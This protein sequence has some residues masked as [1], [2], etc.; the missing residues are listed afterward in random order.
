MRTAPAFLLVL[1][2]MPVLAQ[3]AITLPPAV[4]A[5]PAATA[6]SPDVQQ[7]LE[8]EVVALKGSSE[9][10]S[11]IVFDDELKPYRKILETLDPN[12]TFTIIAQE[13]KPVTLN[14]EERFTVNG[15]Y[16]AY[17]KPLGTRETPEGGQRHELDMR[18]EMLSGTDYVNALRARGEAADR[19]AMVLRGMNLDVGELIVLIRVVPSGQDS[20]G[21]DGDPSEQDESGEQ[22]QEQQE[23]QQQRDQMAE[24]NEDRQDQQQDKQ[25]D[26]E[27]EDEEAPELKAAQEGEHEA[28]ESGEEEMAQQAEGEQEGEQSAVEPQDMET[29]QAILE[30]LEEKDRQEQRNAR[31]RRSRVII[32]GDWW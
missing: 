18:V 12:D 29:I 7:P 9:S 11:A 30:S 27:G 15:L 1:L 32:K 14:A 28:E 22:Q 26:G 21:Q 4:G 24:E 19:Q 2:S 23:Q 6:P 5:P 17:V 8:I 16:T 13:S 10:R 3:P 25:D 20:Q 31:Y